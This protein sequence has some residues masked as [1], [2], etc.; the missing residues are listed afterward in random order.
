MILSYILASGTI[1]GK[2]FSINFFLLLYFGSW[3]V[4]TVSNCILRVKTS[5]CIISV[6]GANIGVV[7]IVD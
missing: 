5:T 6:V 3:F 7:A 4:S 2:V 1:S